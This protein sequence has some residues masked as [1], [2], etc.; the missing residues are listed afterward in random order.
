MAVARRIS[1]HPSPMALV[2]SCTATTTFA[3]FGNQLGTSQSKRSVRFHSLGKNESR[4]HEA[5]R[6]QEKRRNFADAD[7]NCKKHGTVEPHT[8]IDNRESQRGL[9]RCAPPSPLS[10]PFFPSSRAN[11]KLS[12]PEV[13]LGEVWRC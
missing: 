9:Q 5:H 11:R 13:G 8:N 7:A 6:R 2:Q 1:L 3:H 10:R 12:G 4:N